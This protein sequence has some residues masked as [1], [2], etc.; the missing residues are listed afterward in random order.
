[1]AA[2]QGVLLLLCS[3]LMLQVLNMSV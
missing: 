1:M 3:F 2:A